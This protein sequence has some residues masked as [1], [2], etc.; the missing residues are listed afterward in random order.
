MEK[1]DNYRPIPYLYLVEELEK[2]GNN[3][4]PSEWPDILK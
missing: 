1:N 2:N 4:N 3:L